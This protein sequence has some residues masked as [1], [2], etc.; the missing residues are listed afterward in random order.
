MKSEFTLVMVNFIS[1]QRFSS[2]NRLLSARWYGNRSEKRLLRTAKEGPPRAADCTE[3]AT[4]GGKL[5]RARPTQPDMDPLPEDRLEANGWP[6]KYIGLDYL[7]PLFVTVGRRT[8]KRWVALFTCLTTRAIHLEMAHDLSTDSC[9]IAIRNFMSRRGPVVRIRGDNGKNN[10]GADREAKRFSEVFDPLQIQGELSSKGVEWIFNCPAN[11]A[12]GGAWE[13]MV[14][15]VKKVLAHTMKELA[16]K[17]HVLENLLI[18]GESI[19]NSRPL[20]HLPVT[21]DQEAPLTPNNL[22]KGAPDVPDLPKDD[23]QESVRC[24]TRKQWRIARMMRD[25]FWKRWVHEYLPTLVRREKWCKRVEPIRQGD[26]V[27]ICDPAIPR[28]EWKRGEMEYLVERQCGLTIEPRRQC[29]P[30][31]S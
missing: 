17:E 22:L 27:F 15:C 25:R 10:V 3:A 7:G 12:E 8:E 2:Y 14:Q 26:L 11:P 24:T 19:V 20:T 6:F 29:V 18:E 21:V 5:R 28:R 13:R 30:L 4:E 1:L 31:R 9:I 23:G 16:P